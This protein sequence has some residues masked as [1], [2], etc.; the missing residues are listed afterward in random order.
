VPLSSRRSPRADTSAARPDTS[1]PPLRSHCVRPI[2]GTG[3]REKPAE[4]SR[5]GVNGG[6]SR[7]PEMASEQHFCRFAAGQKTA[8]ITFTRQR[9][10]DRDPHRPRQNRSSEGRG[11]STGAPTR[12]APR[13][14]P[15]NPAALAAPGGHQR[16]LP[17]SSPG[18]RGRPDPT[19]RG[20]AGGGRRGPSHRAGG[21]PGQV[22][23]CFG[24][25][26]AAI[27]S[28]TAVCRRS[29][30]RRGS[31]PPARIAGRQW[32]VRHGPPEGSLVAARRT[33]SRIDG[34]SPPRG[35]RP[36]GGS[37]NGRVRQWLGRSVASGSPATAWP[38]SRSSH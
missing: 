14:T 28:D 8:R 15:W 16:A 22:A 4:C 25:A 27:H 29:W 21:V 30:G 13:E 17:G 37:P 2:A 12:S 5:T 9:S 38:A 3:T 20:P 31:R 10:G 32:R 26:P 19:P 33:Q 1:G 11:S 7:T 34:R 18:R 36:A 6:H 24:L 35:P 23:T